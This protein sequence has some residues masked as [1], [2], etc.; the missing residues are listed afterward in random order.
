MSF[1]I[2]QIDYSSPF[3]HVSAGYRS[4]PCDSTTSPKSLRTRA[5]TDTQIL[6]IWNKPLGDGYKFK[7]TTFIGAA[8]VKTTEGFMS[9]G[10]IGAVVVT[11][12][13]PNQPYTFKVQHDCVYTP[14]TSSTQ[15]TRTGTTL[16]PGK[17]EN[18]Y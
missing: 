17:L 4:V 6:L 15:K 18:N 10:S 8:V 7:I 1:A 16:N 12:L 14:G 3:F 5:L 13:Q 9:Y 11:G 2:F